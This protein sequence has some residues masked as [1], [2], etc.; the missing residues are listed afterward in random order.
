MRFLTIGAFCM[1]FG[2]AALADYSRNNAALFCLFEG[3]KID[4]LENG[5]VSSAGEVALRATNSTNLT[6]S[7]LAL[8]AM[9][10]GLDESQDSQVIEWPLPSNLSP[11]ETVIGHVKA[12]AGAGPLLQ[13]GV[14]NA[15]DQFGHRI[16]EREAFYGSMVVIWPDVPLSEFICK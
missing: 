16:I 9:F 1:L 3:V 2:T 11:G 14:G 12:P 13:V 5:K 15:L 10:E 4:V 6:L 7:N 8:E